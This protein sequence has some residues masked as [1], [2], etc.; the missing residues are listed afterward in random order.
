MF[1]PSPSGRLT[2]TLSADATAFLIDNIC[3]RNSKVPAFIMIE[4]EGDIRLH[5]VKVYNEFVLAVKQ[6]LDHGLYVYNAR[7]K[8]CFRPIWS[9]EPA[10]RTL[11]NLTYEP[12]RLVPDQK[13]YDERLPKTTSRLFALEERDR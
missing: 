6:A 8:K 7:T 1:R 3:G 13:V 2:C 12:V 4:P 10:E 9:Q 11:K 5:G